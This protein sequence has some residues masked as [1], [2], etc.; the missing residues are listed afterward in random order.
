[1]SALT[2]MTLSTTAIAG[3]SLTLSQETALGVGAVITLYG[4]WLCWGASEYRM[5]VEERL[6]DG[7]MSD[8]TARRKIARRRL[9]GP[10]ITVIGMIVLTLAITKL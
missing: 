8:E 9:L 7:K 10:G 6:K 5:W 3:W 2:A 4:V 1:M